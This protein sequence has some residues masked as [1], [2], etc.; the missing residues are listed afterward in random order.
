MGSDACGSVSQVLHPALMRLWLLAQK[1]EVVIAAKSKEGKALL[2]IAQQKPD[3]FPGIEALPPNLQQS[4]LL[5][6]FTYLH[7]E[8]GCGL[9]AMETLQG[10][11]AEPKWERAFDFII[12]IPAYFSLSDAG[13]LTLKDRDQNK[14]V[15]ASEYSDVSGTLV[16]LEADLNDLFSSLTFSVNEYAGNKDWRKIEKRKTLLKDLLDLR[17]SLRS[18]SMAISTSPYLQDGKPQGM[19]RTK[20]WVEVLYG[21]TEHAGRLKSLAESY[22]PL[23]DLAEGESE[24]VRKV[25]YE[26]IVRGFSSLFDKMVA[27]RDRFDALPLA[28]DHLM[29]FATQVAHYDTLFRVGS[30]RVVFENG[31]EELQRFFGLDFPNGIGF[32]ESSSGPVTSLKFVGVEGG[33]SVYGLPALAGGLHA[34]FCAGTS[35]FV[36]AFGLKKGLIGQGLLV[37]DPVEGKAAP[38]IYF[39]RFK[40]L[41]DHLKDLVLPFFIVDI[42][43]MEDS[44]SAGGENMGIKTA[45][46]DQM[47]NLYAR[48]EDLGFVIEN[49]SSSPDAEFSGPKRVERWRESM[50][51]AI[52][53]L[54]AIKALGEKYFGECSTVATTTLYNALLAGR[55]YTAAP[56]EIFGG[57]LK[58]QELEQGRKV[59]FGELKLLFEEKLPDNA[60]LEFSLAGNLTLE[61]GAYISPFCFVSVVESLM[62]IAKDHGGVGGGVKV[63]VSTNTQ[64]DEVVLRIRHSG[65]IKQEQLEAV[66]LIEEGRERQTTQRL[67]LM[68][69]AD[70]TACGTC[71]S[72]WVVRDVVEYMQGKVRAFNEGTDAVIELTLKRAV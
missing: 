26:G 34:S 44:L 66:P 47:R 48:L 13:V 72:G 57:K 68:T 32:S 43:S 9:E 18:L 70:K 30:Q 39:W 50:E 8:A 27:L 15:V 1:R 64:G 52:A 69:E 28:N 33:V 42:N 58:R 56:K 53:E 46:L 54:A 59:S 36:P 67:F 3:R 7:F 17:W 5:D 45:I 23:T 21:I 37:R 35:L 20:R 14:H 51:A 60:N 55:D 10:A 12:N 31:S 29:A 22:F 49:Y 38:E 25:A 62:Q 41:A 19:I 63:V 24:Q 11:L 61:E 65:N 2:D 71:S 16:K 40:R 4:P 6:V